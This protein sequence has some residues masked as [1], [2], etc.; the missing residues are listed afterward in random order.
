MRY[1]LEIAYDG[2]KYHGWQIQPNAV[3]V[4]EEIQG[5][6]TLIF[7]KETSCIGC[8]RTDSGVHASQFYLHFDSEKIEDKSKFIHQMNGI[9]KRA[10]AVKDL[11]PVHENA[12]AR[13]DAKARTYQYFI[14]QSKN[15]FLHETSMYVPFDLDMD[16]MNEAGHYLCTVSDFASFCKAHG[17]SKTTLCDLMLCQWSRTDQQLILTIKAN[18]FLRNMVRAVVGSM[19]EIGRK[20]ISIQ[21][22]EK[23]VQDKDRSGAGSSADACGLFLTRI[24]YPY[25]N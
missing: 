23:I 15:P 10:I 21:D 14:H 1:F 13:F 8:G 3:S 24:E 6:L 19:I 12:H 18:R 5:A 11:I 20:K 16:L 22:F 9:L 25:F 2:S 4:Q 17:D 7:K